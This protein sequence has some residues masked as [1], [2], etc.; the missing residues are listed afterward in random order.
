MEIHE[1]DRFE[2]LYPDNSKLADCR[3]YVD[4]D[5]SST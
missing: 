3:A 4:K 2:L 5:L 1:S